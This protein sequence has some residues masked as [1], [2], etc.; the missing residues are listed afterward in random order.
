MGYRLNPS[1]AD[2][3][4]GTTCLI[5]K[6]N[7]RDEQVLSEIE[8]QITFTKASMLEIELIDGSFDFEH[9]KSIHKFLF[10]EL[11]DWA[12]TIRI[13]DIVKKR[14]SFT[15]HQDIER[16]GT[17]CL[18]KIQNGYLDDLSFDKFVYKIADLYHDINMLHPFREGNGRTQRMFFAQLIMHYDYS[19]SFSATDTDFLMIATIQAAQGVLDGLVEFFSEVIEAPQQNMTM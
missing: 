15:K 10:D 1:S 11:Y 19:I 4:E 13:T 9:Y 2:C 6:L 16:I 8:A 3:Y 17:A 5:N 18:R 12:G 14:T 7:I